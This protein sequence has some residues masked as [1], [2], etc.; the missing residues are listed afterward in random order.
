MSDVPV[1]GPTA[2]GESH[3]EFQRQMMMR[4]HAVNLDGLEVRHVSEESLLS[5]LRDL[6]DGFVD[7]SNFAFC[8]WLKC[9]ALKSHVKQ[10]LFELQ[11]LESNHERAIAEVVGRAAGRQAGTGRPEPEA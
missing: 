11:T 3:L 7:Q 6:Q 2:D 10:L 1:A 4:F 8:C 9:E 5:L